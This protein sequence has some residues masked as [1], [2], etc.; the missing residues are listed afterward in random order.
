MDINAVAAVY[1]HAY[2]TNVG[3]FI[4]ALH[5]SLVAAT[6]TDGGLPNIPV[7]FASIDKNKLD[8]GT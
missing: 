1:S 5:V 2:R 4:D 8:D 3:S 7:H 6:E